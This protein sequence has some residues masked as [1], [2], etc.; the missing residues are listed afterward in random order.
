MLCPDAMLGR[1]ASVARSRMPQE[2]GERLDSF[3]GEG[4]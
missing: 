2:R 4:L 1:T 3:M